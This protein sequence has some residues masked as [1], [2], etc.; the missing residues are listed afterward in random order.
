MIN[1][2]LWCSKVSFTVIVLM[3]GNMFYE[4]HSN[5]YQEYTLKERN[6]KVGCVF[7]MSKQ[8]WNHEKAVKL[9]L[10]FSA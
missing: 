5:G 9:Y 2:N 1:K 4:D 10:F 8:L 3:T 7:T 6:V